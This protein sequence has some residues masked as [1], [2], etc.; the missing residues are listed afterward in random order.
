MSTSPASPAESDLE[1]KT[2]PASP[3]TVVSRKSPP[4][5]KRPPAAMVQGIVT[6]DLAWIVIPG[7]NCGGALRSHAES[8]VFRH[9]DNWNEFGAV[10]WSIFV[11]DLLLAVERRTWEP[12]DKL[13]GR[14]ADHIQILLW[15]A[16]GEIRRGVRQPGSAKTCSE[17]FRMLNLGQLAG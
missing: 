6:A 8:E 13:K 17:T 11:A 1:P 9:Y 15:M 4:S 7:W 2:S 16:K 3:C 12:T 14:N 10:A 5:Y